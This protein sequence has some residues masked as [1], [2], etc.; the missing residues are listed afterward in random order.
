MG[1]GWRGGGEM[2]AGVGEGRFQC[3]KIHQCH[4]VPQWRDFFSE[5]R[6]FFVDEE[7]GL[8]SS[9]LNFYDDSGCSPLSD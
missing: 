2:R 3:T 4:S 7:S 8:S 5:Q 1:K 9:G 6:I